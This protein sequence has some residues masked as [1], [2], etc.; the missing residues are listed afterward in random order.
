MLETQRS[1]A[2]V[3]AYLRKSMCGYDGKDPKV[4]C[5]LN[6]KNTN[7]PQPLV[8]Q[9]STVKLVSLGSSGYETVKSQKLPSQKMCGRTNSTHIRVIGGQPSELGRYV[10]LV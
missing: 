5:R 3:V 9:P 10:I 7:T 2:T 8:S 1:N 4:C 6:D